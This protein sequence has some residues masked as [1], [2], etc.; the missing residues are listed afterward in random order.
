MNIVKKIV[1]IWSLTDC[2]WS[3]LVVIAAL[4]WAFVSVVDAGSEGG[5]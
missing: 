2:V 1:G 3:A 4:V 5:G